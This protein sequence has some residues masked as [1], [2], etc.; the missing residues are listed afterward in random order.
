MM[1]HFHE[2]FKREFND[3]Y[4]MADGSFNKRGMSLQ[5]YLRQ[6]NSLNSHL[7]MHHT[8]EE[9]EIFP[10][11][12]ERMPP[13]AING[14]HGGA[15]LMSHE[16]IHEGLVKLEELVRKFKSDP[17]SYSPKEM[18]DCLDGFRQVLFEHLDEEVEDLKGENLKKY[19]TLEEIRKIVSRGF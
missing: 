13:F 5:L 9:R 7:T 4:D 15:H 3:I 12:G 11:L 19:W 8:I 6:A 10:I 1:S 2:H 18:R 16:G 14:E 17:T